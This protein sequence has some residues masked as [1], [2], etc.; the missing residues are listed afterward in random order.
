MPHPLFDAHAFT[1]AD[2]LSPEELQDFEKSMKRLQGALSKSLLWRSVWTFSFSAF[3]TEEAVILRKYLNEQRVSLAK[4]FPWEIRDNNY[5]EEI[6]TKFHRSYLSFESDEEGDKSQLLQS[7]RAVVEE[8]KRISAEE[9]F[10]KG[11]CLG[12]VSIAVRYVAFSLYDWHQSELS[13][14]SQD[15]PPQPSACGV[16]ATTI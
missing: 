4:L 11:S 15:T 16:L 14:S 9:I 8:A 3:Y 2:H 5:A 6:V 10:S 1:F 13:K 12:A 7:I